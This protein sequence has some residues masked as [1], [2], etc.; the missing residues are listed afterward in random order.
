[1][2]SFVFFHQRVEINNELMVKLNAL[3]H[4]AGI[5]G[6][7]IFFGDSRPHLALLYKISC[8]SYENVNS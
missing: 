2:G 1:M 8:A 7:Y 6:V 3:L 4:R 5:T